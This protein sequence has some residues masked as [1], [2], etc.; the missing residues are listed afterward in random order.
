MRM[1]VIDSED[2]RSECSI[3][4]N[5]VLPI[6]DHVY[7]YDLFR[8]NIKMALIGP[9]TNNTGNTGVGSIIGL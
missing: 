7:I 1:Q 2:N 9:I 8:S 3:D 6:K 4:N 5:P